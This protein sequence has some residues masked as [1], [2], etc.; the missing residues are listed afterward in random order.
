MD[1]RFLVDGDQDACFGNREFAH[2]T[3]R[4][5]HLGQG[6]VG[7]PGIGNDRD[8]VAPACGALVP[9]GPYG[10]HALAGRVVHG[11][12]HVLVGLALEGEIGQV[13]QGFFGD[14]H[15]RPALLARG[16]REF[17]VDRVERG[18]Q[19][20]GGREGRELCD[21][22]GGLARFVREVGDRQR[23]AARPAV[24]GPRLARLRHPHLVARPRLHPS[25]R[26]AA[27]G[28]QERREALER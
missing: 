9:G 16:L 17:L 20:R 24:G 3:E 4:K 15:D 13:E 18:G 21:G 14:L 26:A 11:G 12:A 7:T 22:F 27:V 28:A 2:A 23:D 1:R 8:L 6:L 19:A 10:R 5:A 25:E